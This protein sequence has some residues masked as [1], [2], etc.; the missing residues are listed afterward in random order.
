MELDE[1][2][3]KLEI[4]PEEI[5]SI[6]HY[7]GP[8]HTEINFLSNLNI[9]FYESIQKT[10]ILPESAE[11]VRSQI[12]DFIN[13]CSAMYKTSVFNTCDFKLVKGSGK[14]VANSIRSSTN[15][16]LST[17]TDMDVAKRFCIYPEQ[18]LF[19][20]EPSEDVPFLDV[21]QY[22]EDGQREDEIILFP[23]CKVVKNEEYSN[24]DGY[25]YRTLKL[26]KEELEVVSQ[27]ELDKLMIDVSE[28]FI[29]NIQ[30]INECMDIDIQL[31]SIEG[32]LKNAQTIDDKKDILARKSMLVSERNMKYQEIF[33]FQKKM[34]T[35]LKGLCKQKELEIDKYKEEYKQ[36]LVREQQ[37]KDE[38]IRRGWLNSAKES[39]SEIISIAEQSE[40]TVNNEYENLVQ[41][42]NFYINQA[43]YLGV[44]FSGFNQ[45]GDLKQSLELFKKHLEAF[46]QKLEESKN[47]IDENET[48]SFYISE[49][50]KIQ[51]FDADTVEL[52]HELSALQEIVNNYK[53]QS[54][55]EIKQNLAKKVQDII[56]EQ[57]IR[58]YEEEHKKLCNTK[59][60]FLGKLFGKEKLRQEQIENL[61]LLIKSV[62]LRS[63]EEIDV[64]N[65]E[66]L[67]VNLYVCAIKNRDGNFSSEMVDIYSK[68]KSVYNQ[69]DKSD[70]SDEKIHQLAT[71][72]I[73]NSN[74][75]VPIDD[76]KKKKTKEQIRVL[77]EENRQLQSQIFSQVGKNNNS[78]KNN[79][80]NYFT[81]FA[82]SVSKI[83]SIFYIKGITENFRESKLD[84]VQKEGGENTLLWPDM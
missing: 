1:I 75:L 48:N 21:E 36:Y 70:F 24:W 53:I 68:I 51:S 64:I 20:V 47:S 46:K 37:K 38:E 61:E 50:R 76:N 40:I 55:N 45:S 59:V 42:E 56:K 54:E 66:E 39:Y 12:T 7:M 25:Q 49:I 11:E 34:Q 58:K 30:T 22:R 8:F 52:E 17:T 41:L 10:W 16:F 23:F 35:L 80:I 4:S 5:K 82:N 2:K 33:D 65:P 71:E 27:D 6:K 9:G 18:V 44:D 81:R 73:A 74:S 31:A 57:E 78:L 14:T 62:S 77:H 29:K 69:D 28:G 83:A 19:Y 72:R 26:E 32:M 84:Q 3:E 67:L 15:Q 43:R 60:V 79:K 63:V 13:I